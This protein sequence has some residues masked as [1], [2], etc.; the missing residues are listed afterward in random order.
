MDHAFAVRSSETMS[1][2]CPQKR[3][4]VGRKRP[5]VHLLRERDPLNHFHDQVDP[6]FIVRKQI[7]TMHDRWMSDRQ[8]GLRLS[9]EKFAGA[10]LLR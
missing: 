8:E 6:T 4:L 1:N 2:P 7:V 5:V 9:V 3:D 10:L